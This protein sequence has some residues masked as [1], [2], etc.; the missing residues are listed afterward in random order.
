MVEVSA[1]KE[2]DFVD[3]Q[4]SKILFTTSVNL[5]LE[6]AFYILAKRFRSLSADQ[7]ISCLD[8]QALG[9]MDKPDTNLQAQ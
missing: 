5:K 4:P 9:N 2:G 6:Y 3:L 1:S 8:I 7:D